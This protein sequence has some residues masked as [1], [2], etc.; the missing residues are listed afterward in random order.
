MK[1][2]S[3]IIGF[4]IIFCIISGFSTVSAS[5]IQADAVG[6]A[7]DYQSNIKLNQENGFESISQNYD[8]EENIQ[9]DDE[10]V[11][12]QD[13]EPLSFNQFGADLNSSGSE[14]NMSHDYAYDENDSSESCNF[15][16]ESL[17]I[18]G[19]NHVLDGSGSDFKFSF[20]PNADEP[21]PSVNLVI[22]DLTIKNF[23]TFPLDLSVYTVTLNNVNF[24]EC[25][26]NVPLFGPME[27]FA[28]TV[29]NCNFYS[30]S[31]RGISFFYRNTID[32]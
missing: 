19:N 14:F 2:K 6:T 22:N 9:S 24:T 10:S 1:I 26:D 7:D 29:N 12:S 21:S 28:V 11:L 13:E 3:A 25:S 31:L 5:E 15:I 23:T 17:T 18:N 27:L 32:R 20:Y 16:I 30:D 8:V 4:L